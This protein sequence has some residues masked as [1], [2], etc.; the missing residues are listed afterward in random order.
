MV[1]VDNLV[2]E[3]VH[4]RGDRLEAFDLSG[5][6]CHFQHQADRAKVCEAVVDAKNQFSLVVGMGMA[7]FDDL[8]FAT[9]EEVVGRRVKSLV[10][11]LEGRSLLLISSRSHRFKWPEL[12]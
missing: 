10:F 8:F 11:D 12:V 1:Q 4:H 9:V 2:I 5:V 6:P 7:V 3:K